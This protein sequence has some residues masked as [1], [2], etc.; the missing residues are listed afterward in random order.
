MAGQPPFMNSTSLISKIFARL[1]E[2]DK[3]TGG[4]VAWLRA[5]WY[6][7]LALMYTGGIAALSAANFPA[8]S[9]ALP[10]DPGGN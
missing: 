9:L 4:T 10:K 2:A 5:G 7:I 8:L 1:A 6:P 3:G